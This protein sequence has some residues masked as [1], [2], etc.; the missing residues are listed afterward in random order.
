MFRCDT[1][2]Y[3]T[4][5]VEKVATREKKNVL[6]NKQLQQQRTNHNKQRESRR[7]AKLPACTSHLTDAQA[8]MC[9]YPL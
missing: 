4:C 9:N 6:K 7:T 3:V 5:T 2:I 1:Y 8:V